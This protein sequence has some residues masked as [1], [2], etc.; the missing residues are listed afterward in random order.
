MPTTRLTRT[1]KRIL[2]ALAA[3][4][5]IEADRFGSQTVRVREFG[6]AVSVYTTRKTVRAM[7]EKGLL[8]RD[9]RL[10]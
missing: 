5:Y 2:E 7:V 6:K 9:W 10:A 8:N 1:E 3:G 4:C